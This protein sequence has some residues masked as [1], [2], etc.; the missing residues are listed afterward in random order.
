MFQD[1]CQDPT[2]LTACSAVLIPTPPS[3]RMGRRTVLE[4]GSVAVA[5]SGGSIGSGGPGPEPLKQ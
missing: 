4:G 5:G 1:D 3:G 2:T